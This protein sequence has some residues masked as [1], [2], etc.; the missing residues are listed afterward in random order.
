[1]SVT[2]EQYQNGHTVVYNLRQIILS[3]K[4][5]CFGVFPSDDHILTSM[6]CKFEDDG[7]I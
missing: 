3:P 4:I 2:A 6:Q 7:A 1:M 5:L